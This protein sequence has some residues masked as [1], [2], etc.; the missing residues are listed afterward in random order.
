MLASF[1]VLVAL[2]MFA[3]VGGAGGDVHDSMPD[4]AGAASP[5]GE[6]E[7][8][9]SSRIGED[10]TGNSTLAAVRDRA[11]D[12][13][14]PT[15]PLMARTSWRALAIIGD[16]S[17]SPAFGGAGV[18]G[19]EEAIADDETPRGAR[20]ALE[21]WFLGNF[22]GC[23]NMESRRLGFSAGTSLPART[24]MPWPGLHPKYVTWSTRPPCFPTLSSSTT[25]YQMPCPLKF[26]APM[27]R[28][29]PACR[30]PSTRHK[31]R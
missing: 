25:P 30:L 4:R 21:P 29:F 6:D 10:E 1:G 2:N 24:K 28:I 23:G 7:T 14:A 16:T 31:T 12:F 26:V 22:L 8:G 15:E 27:K 20:T 11:G 19:K 13:V 17:A 18:G 3:A 9:S 5:A